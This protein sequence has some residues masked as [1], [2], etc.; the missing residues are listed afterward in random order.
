MPRRGISSGSSQIGSITF[1]IDGSLSPSY[2]DNENNRAEYFAAISNF[3]KGFDNFVPNFQLFDDLGDLYVEVTADFLILE[4]DLLD[5]TIPDDTDNTGYIEFTLAFSISEIVGDNNITINEADLSGILEL[6]D[7]QNLFP[8]E[9]RSEIYY[10][11]DLEDYLTD[12]LEISSDILINEPINQFFWQTEEIFPDLTFFKFNSWDDKIIVSNQTGTNT[13]SPQIT[14]ND[15]IYLDWLMTNEG[16]A[17]V[18][19]PIESRILLDGV[20]LARISSDSPFYATQ[21]RLTEDYNIGSLSAG[22]HTI[23]IELDYLNKIEESNETNNTY[24]RNFTVVNSTTPPTTSLLNT[25]IYRFQNAQLPGTYLFVGEI[26]RD[27]ILTN[28]PQFD[29][30]GF[31]F[32][33]ANQPADNLVRFNRFQNSLV[34]GTYL[35]ATEGESMSIRQNFPEFEEEGIAF[36]AYSADADIGTD[37]YRFQNNQVPGTYLFVNAEERQS[38][39]QNFPQFVEE[40][41]AFEVFTN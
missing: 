20:E 31:A 16:E 34:P 22:T 32:Y 21:T 41:V 12:T 30:E 13:S 8:D 23:T 9:N 25:P 6:L 19:I 1:E 38:I 18:S 17:Q 33:V 26:E 29:L 5:F 2:I 36:Y 37:Y 27:N 28:F 4:I 7:N 14:T 39:L 3:T 40:G 10:S 15:T 35:Y 24:S 11:P